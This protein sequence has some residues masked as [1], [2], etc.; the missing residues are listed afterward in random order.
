MGTSEEAGLRAKERHRAL[1]RGQVDRYHGR[2][3]ENPGDQTL[4]IFDN[5]L[6]AA[7]CALAIQAETESEHDVRLH[8][9]IHLGDVLVQGGE[10]HGDGVNIAARL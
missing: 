3:I 9:G 2:L 8:I 1:V 10:I 5:A 7:N 6:D 4:S